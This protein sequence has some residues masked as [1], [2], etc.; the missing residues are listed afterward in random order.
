MINREKIIKF[1]HISISVIV[2]FAFMI[3]GFAFQPEGIWTYILMLFAFLIPLVTLII[4]HASNIKYA[5]MLRSMDEDDS[6]LNQNADPTDIVAK[7]TTILK[8]IIVASDV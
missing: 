1:L 3:L 8:R 2:L 4:G 7:E 5:R 6:L